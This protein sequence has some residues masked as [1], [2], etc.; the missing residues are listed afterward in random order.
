MQRGFNLRKWSSNEPSVLEEVPFENRLA[1]LQIQD[2]NLP[3]QKML[4]DLWKA[5]EDTF[6]FEVEIP[7]TKG[8]LTK[9]GVLS[10]IATLFDL[11]Q[12]LAPFTVLAKILMQK[13]WMAVIGW[14]YKLPSQLLMKW[15]QWNSEL[16]ELLQFMIP[17]CLHQPNPSICSS[18]YST[19]LPMLRRYTLP[20]NCW[21]Q[22]M[23]GKVTVARY[24][25]ETYLP[26]KTV[27]IS[28]ETLIMF[29]GF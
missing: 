14:D 1:S 28:E 27:N 24:S 2:E 16:L 29:L 19:C 12:F 15:Q 20:F 25:P 23:K 18:K 22:T 8:N 6:T 13:I 21:T 11:L 9:R 4:G 7:E 10:S 26:H 3:V 5:Y 17:C